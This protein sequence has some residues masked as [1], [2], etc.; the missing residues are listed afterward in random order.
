MKTLMLLS[1]A[2]LLASPA[3]ADVVYLNDGAEISG[4]VTAVDAASVS[5][6][7]GGKKTAYPRKDVMRVQLVKEYSAAADPLKDPELSRLLAARPSPDAYPND[8][9]L[10][11]LTEIE[12]TINPDRSWTTSR[13]SVR[14][15]LRERGKSPA[16]Y[17]SSTFLPGLEK[18]SIDYAFS[19]TDSSVSWLNDL[20]VMDGSPFVGYPSYDRARLIKAAIPNVQ[21]GSALDYRYRTDTVYAS[22][23]PFFAEF[24]MRGYEPVKTWRL[25]VNVPENLKLKY[26]VFNQP[27]G[28]AFSRTDKGGGS[29]Y[30]WEAYDLPSY[31]SEQNSPPY[32]RYAPHV[33][34][35]LEGDSWDSLKGSL[36]EQLRALL[37]ITP[38]MRAKAAELTAGAAGDEARAEALYNWTAREIKFQDV[39]LDDFS[40]LPRPS[41]QVFATKAGNALDKPFLLYAMMTAAGLSPEFAYAHTKYSPFREDMPNIRQF[42]SAECL[43]SAAGR[44]LTL[45]PLWDSYRYD[46]LVSTLQGMPAFKVLGAGPAIVTN[47]DRS[48]DEEYSRT[49]ASYSL[50]ADGGLSGSFAQKVRGGYQ[51]SMRGYKDYKKA[52]LDRDMEKIAHSVHPTARLRDY[53]FGGL[54]DLSRDL[55]FGLSLDAAGYAMKAG[56]YILFK[57]PGLGYSAAGA[58]QTE[59]E[60]PLFWYSRGLNARRI[61]IK[62]PPGYALYHAPKPLDLK[63]AGETYKAGFS[64]AAGTL[65]FTEEFRTDNTWIESKD[66]PQYKALKEAMAALSEDWVVLVKK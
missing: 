57:L 3:S 42:D 60:L 56:K 32:L 14:Y 15:V 10:N 9:L 29:V 4:A 46:E 34:L 8:G 51:A 20:S 55:D 1:A 39:G 21:I 6:L 24:A 65:T 48:S 58:A 2:F 19:V 33:V 53:R 37:V 41:D 63:L 18:V 45:A 61:S 25:I 28:A 17:F 47:P 59:R 40:Y 5:V 38:E 31:R 7:A 35:S 13:R 62:L 30:V 64:A 43:L 54:D 66:Y 50:G 52:D 36:A 11:W 26:S 44:E 22:T 12:V 49:E 23:Y 27:K 16:A